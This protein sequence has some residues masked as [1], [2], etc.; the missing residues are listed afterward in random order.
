MYTKL[1]KL[2]SVISPCFR[3]KC[4]LKRKKKKKK[5][6]TPTLKRFYKKIKKKKKKWHS[7]FLKIFQVSA[8]EEM[9]A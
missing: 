3:L 6:D 5:K 2:V 7:I 4:Q 8:D 1:T 9:G